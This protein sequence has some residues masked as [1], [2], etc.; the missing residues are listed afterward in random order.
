MKGDWFEAVMHD[1]LGAT[2]KFCSRDFRWCFYQSIS[3]AKHVLYFHDEYMMLDVY[4]DDYIIN[5]YR[6]YYIVKRSV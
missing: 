2:Y 6:G 1:V 5:V 3:Y 4:L